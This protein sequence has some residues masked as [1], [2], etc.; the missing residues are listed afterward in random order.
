M[1]I[2]FFFTGPR[3]GFDTGLSKLRNGLE[4]LTT[5][6]NKI[7]V[8]PETNTMTVG[9]A[10]RFQDVANALYAVKKNIRKLKYDSRLR[11]K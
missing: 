2:P 9:G 3:H 11:V 7:N 4:I 8:E 5:S 6:F 10:V 1:S